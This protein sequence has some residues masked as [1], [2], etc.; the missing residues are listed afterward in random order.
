MYQFA[1]KCLLFETRDDDN[2]YISSTIL[3]PFRSISLFDHVPSLISLER[4]RIV[5][6]KSYLHEDKIRR[7]LKCINFWMCSQFTKE[8]SEHA[9]QEECQ[10]KGNPQRKN[11]KL[12]HG[13]TCSL[14]KLQM[15]DIWV[16]QS[17]NVR[18][19]MLMK[20]KDLSN[21]FI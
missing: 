13:K 9:V 16:K 10:R 12:L 6:S 1:Q 5:W 14:S 3:K 20:R 15:R 17:L 11:E 4:C 18:Q 7:C 8:I 19:T 21:Q 2:N